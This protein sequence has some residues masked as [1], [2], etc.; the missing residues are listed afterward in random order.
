MVGIACAPG[1]DHDVAAQDQTGAAGRDPGR[2]DL[3]LA[4]GDPQMGED[5]PALLR[6]ARHVEDG[7]AL[8]LE[9]SGHAEQGPDRHHAG[10]ADA[11]D[12][13]AVR[14]VER[15]QR[16]SGRTG[17]GTSPATATC[18]TCRP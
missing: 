9:V 14:A 3:G 18:A 5:R 13:D 1:G 4:R 8:A 15:G 16:G 12:D 11:G 2:A 6:H 10:A 7:D 17:N